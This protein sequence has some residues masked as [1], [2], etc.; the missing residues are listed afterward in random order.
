MNPKGK[1]PILTMPEEWVSHAES[2]LAIAR[3][4]DGKPGVL[5]QQICFHAQQAAEK[6]L[7]AVLLFHKIDFAWTHDITELT[8]IFEEAGI[9]LPEDFQDAGD[10]TPYAVE[11]RYP[12]YWGTIDEEDV[13]EA[14]E[15]AEKI[16]KWARESIAG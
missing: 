11:S 6:A 14:I 16:V 2:D 15:L 1:K 8:D 12:G 9:T 4:G 7:K 10:L 3:L 13:K 5:P